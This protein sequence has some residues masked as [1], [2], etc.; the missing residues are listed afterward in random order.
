MKG[1]MRFAKLRRDECVQ[2][3][4]YKEISIKRP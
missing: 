4:L 1:E 3:D 2:K